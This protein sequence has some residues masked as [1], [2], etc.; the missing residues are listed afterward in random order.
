MHPR[1]LD[2]LRKQWKALAASPREPEKAIEVRREQTALESRKY[3]ER[4][5]DS[6]REPSESLILPWRAMDSLRKHVSA[7]ENLR[8]P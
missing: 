5:L 7:L 2:I 1:A 4:A 6:L 3:P 8:K